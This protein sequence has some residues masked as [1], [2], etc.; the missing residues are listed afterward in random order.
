MLAACSML[1]MLMCALPYNAVQCSTQCIDS[2]SLV[3]TVVHC[4][5]NA[6]CAR[7]RKWRRG[8][9]AVASWTPSRAH[10]PAFTADCVQHIVCNTHNSKFCTIFTL[11][12]FFVSSS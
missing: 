3:C 1:R 4:T 5:E 6:W 7:D 8:V 11:C 10:R 12:N 9:R 2:K